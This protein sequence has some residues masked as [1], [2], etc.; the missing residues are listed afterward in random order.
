M[1][2]GFGGH[3][4]GNFMDKNIRKYVFFFF[5]INENENVRTNVRNTT[6]RLNK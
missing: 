1:K 3:G 6:R 2:S 5:N 4:F